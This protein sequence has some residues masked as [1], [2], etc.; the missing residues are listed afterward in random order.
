MLKKSLL[1]VAIALTPLSVF[2]SSVHIGGDYFLKGAE[3]A[4]DDLYVLGEIG[5]FAGTATGDIVSLAGTNISEG[6]SKADVLLL[7]GDVMLGGT[8]GDDARLVGETVTIGGVVE[9]DTLVFGARV[10]LLPSANIGGNLYI[11]GADVTIEGRVAGDVRVYGKNVEI[12]GTIGGNLET[13]GTVVIRPGTSIGG[14]FTYHASRLVVIPEEVSVKG[15]TLF[16]PL[17]EKGLTLFAGPSFRGGFFSL[18]ALMALGLT[19]SLFF[20]A[21]RRTEETLLDILLSFWHRA[22]RGLLIVICAP[23]SIAVLFATVVGAPLAVVLLCIFVLFILLGQAF[24]AL[25][26]GAWCE[27]VFFKRSA[28]P[29]AYR[30]V[31][32][33]TLALSLILLI[34]FLGFLA[35]FLLLLASIGGLG[36]AG[37]RQLTRIR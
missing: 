8:V 22:L 32:I 9:D 10:V 26:V 18:Y 19:F 16:E 7:G 27:R 4:E 24:S 29:L 23:V 1:A 31:I 3:I 28:F 30:T 21:K 25:T 34:P 14:D 20:F 35:E 17:R 37:Y 15:A 13:W 11:V 12:T 36:T 6:D 33:G 2:A 5:T